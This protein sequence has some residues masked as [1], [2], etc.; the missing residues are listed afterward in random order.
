MHTCSTVHVRKSEDHSVESVPTAQVPVGSGHQTQSTG[1]VALSHLASRR[2]AGFESAAYCAWVIPLSKAELNSA[3]DLEWETMVYKWP[4][5]TP[6]VETEGALNCSMPASCSAEG[7]GRQTSVLMSPHRRQNLAAGLPCTDQVT[8]N[9]RSFLHWAG[10][11]R[12]GSVGCPGIAMHCGT[13]FGFSVLVEARHLQV[14]FKSLWICLFNPRPASTTSVSLFAPILL[15]YPTPTIAPRTAVPQDLCT[16]HP[17]PDDFPLSLTLLIPPVESQRPEA[18]AFLP[19]QTRSPI[20]S[21][22]LNGDLSPAG[23]PL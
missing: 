9:S 21:C 13:R 12:R 6:K 20:T 19:E 22:H 15:A 14:A 5:Y 11:T 23:F 3:V 16:R 7:P 1:L 8:P 18:Q 2:V 10:D 17:L 4:P